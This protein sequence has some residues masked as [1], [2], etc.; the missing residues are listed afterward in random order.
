L[1]YPATLSDDLKYLSTYYEWNVEDKKEVR[2]AFTGSPEMVRFFTILA[3]AHRAGYS[4]HAGNGFVRLG[5]WC[6]QNNLGDPYGPDFDPAELHAR[7]VEQR[8]ATR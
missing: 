8:V 3:A 2:A 7:A 4:Q 1:N 5:E 6:I